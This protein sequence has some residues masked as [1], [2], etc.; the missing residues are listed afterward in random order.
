MAG[1]KRNGLDQRQL[2]VIMYYMEGHPKRDCLRMAGYAESTARKRCDRVFNNPMI[3]AEIEKRQAMLREKHELSE[4]WVIQR[5]MM[6]ADSGATLAKYKVIGK[7]GQLSWDF[8]GATEEDLAAINELTVTEK[9]DGTTS[10]K[11]G[12]DSPKSALDS[13][14][15]K[16]GLFNEVVTFRG[17]ISLVDRIRQGRDQARIRHAADR[18]KL[19]GEGKSL[20]D[21]EE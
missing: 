12:T 16:L 19:V 6:I 18:A 10:I 4:D 7:D 2:L 11:I 5:L 8:T 9:A 3:K 20:D 21:E 1:G 14:A 15:R 13:L 17:E